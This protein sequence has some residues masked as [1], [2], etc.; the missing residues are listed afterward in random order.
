MSTPTATKSEALHFEDF[1][2]EIILKVVSYLD[3]N[4][5]FKCSF[6]S[7]R[8][9]KICQDHTLPSMWQKIHLYNPYLIL[10]TLKNPIATF[11]KYLFQI[12]KEKHLQSTNWI[13]NKWR[14]YNG[15]NSCGKINNNLQ[16]RMKNHLN[17]NIQNFNDKSIREIL[18]KGCNYLIISDINTRVGF[19]MISKIFMAKKFSELKEIKFTWSIL[20][21]IGGESNQH[22]HYGSKVLFSPLN[23]PAYGICHCNIGKNKSLQCIEQDILQYLGN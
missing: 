15:Q 20:D 7:N 11:G 12:N 16:Q 1:S 14:C 17:L 5:R 18:D 21:E 23:F 4:D 9:R 19:E 13:H 2:D 10:E 6:T 22:F 8:L 3:L